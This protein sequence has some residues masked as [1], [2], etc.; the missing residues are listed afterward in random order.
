[1][2]VLYR[3]PPASG[4]VEEILADVES[5]DTWLGGFRDHGVEFCNS[6]NHAR[7]IAAY[8]DEPFDFGLVAILDPGRLP[9]LPLVQVEH[10]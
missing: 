1:M 2:L 10:L 4:L 7:I 5:Y 8:S 6:A 3:F 9:R